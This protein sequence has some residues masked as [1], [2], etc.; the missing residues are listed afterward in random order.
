MSTDNAPRSS[1]F[2]SRWPRT[3][4]FEARAQKRLDTLIADL[5]TAQARETALRT[6][7][8]E[9]I[10]RQAM[11]AAEFEHRLINSLQMISSLLSLQGRTA[12]TP[13]AADQL[14]IA[15]HRVAALGRVH[16]QL[17]LLDH[18]ERVELRQ[19]LDQLC[20]DLA[21]LLLDEG[22]GHFIVVQGGEFEIPTTLGIPLGFIVNELI[23]N[24]VK[25]AKGHI[26]VRIETTAPSH[27]LLSVLDEGPGLPAG[28][29]AEKS[30]GL[31]MKIVRSLVK[32]VNGKLSILPG[33]NGRGT[34]FTVAF[35]TDAANPDA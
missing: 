14:K 24:S 25:Y 19:Y 11:M 30:R 6:A 3:E 2:V 23:T 4:A 22:S 20:E 10:R 28:F 31:G 33:E 9:L 5:T 32:Q 7:N 26:I 34:C 18:Q 29:D 35:S 16:R 1:G 8:A 12:T 27:H 21:G 15:A 13:E 17:H